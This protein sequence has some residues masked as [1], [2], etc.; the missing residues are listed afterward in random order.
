MGFHSIKRKWDNVQ[1]TIKLRQSHILSHILRISVLNFISKRTDPSLFYAD[2]I[3]FIIFC[4]YNRTHAHTQAFDAIKN[5]FLRNSLWTYKI[6]VR[7][8]MSSVCFQLSSYLSLSFYWTHKENFPPQV[9][10]EWRSLK[11]WEDRQK[12]HYII[13]CIYLY[14]IKVVK[15]NLHCILLQANGRAFLLM[16]FFCCYWIIRIKL[17]DIRPATFFGPSE[18]HTSANFKDFSN[19]NF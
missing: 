6:C 16:F 19:F 11:N 7:A 9:V 10:Y 14:A 2:V 1:A 8:Y 4:S 15:Q 5:A 17:L 13:I 12:I 3:S 18:I